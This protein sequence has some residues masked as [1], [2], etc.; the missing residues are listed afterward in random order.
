[1][2]EITGI[3]RYLINVLECLP[4]FD[5][6]NKYALFTYNKTRFDEKFYEHHIVSDPSFQDN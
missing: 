2:K 4:K 1:M 5:S 6:K 3:T